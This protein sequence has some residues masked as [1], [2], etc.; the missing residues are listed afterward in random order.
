LW[1]ILIMI[2]EAASVNRKLRSN[3]GNVMKK[4]NEILIVTL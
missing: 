3:Q 1:H 2:F 4:S